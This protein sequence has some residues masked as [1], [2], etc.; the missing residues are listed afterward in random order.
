M[1]SK[2]VGNP[3]GRD[4]K[5]FYKTHPKYNYSFMSRPRCLADGISLMSNK[6]PIFV[7]IIA[8]TKGIYGTERARDCHGVIFIVINDGN[9]RN[10]M[11]NII[12]ILIHKFYDI[13]IWLIYIDYY[14]DPLA[15]QIADEKPIALIIKAFPSMKSNILNMGFG[16]QVNTKNC[17]E[18]CLVEISSI[19]IEDP[20]ITKYK[21]AQFSPI[22]LFPVNN[23]NI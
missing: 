12:L 5:S 17:F 10:C 22:S 8:T 14:W 18:R 19:L 3:H 9:V 16:T 2:I 23:P 15:Y 7:F 13:Y 20:F 6:Y 21:W 4:F 11:Y 1:R